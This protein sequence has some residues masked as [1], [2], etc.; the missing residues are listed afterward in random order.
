MYCTYPDF[1]KIFTLTTDASNNELFSHRTDILVVTFSYKKRITC[2][3][4]DGKTVATVFG[5]KKTY[6]SNG[7]SSLKVVKE[8]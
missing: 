2:N 3:R 1:D 4:M 6:Y 7:S 5:W 8:R